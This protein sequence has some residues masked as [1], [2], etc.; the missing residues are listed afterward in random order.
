MVFDEDVDGDSVMTG[1]ALRWE[2]LVQFNKED[3]YEFFL[4]WTLVQ[5]FERIRLT[6][7]EIMK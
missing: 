5:Q 2:M 4:I 1:M 7:S 6:A 3:G